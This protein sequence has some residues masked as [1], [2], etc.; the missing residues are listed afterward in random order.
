MQSKQ[1]AP[2]VGLTNPGDS[3][4]RK[5]ESHRE[6]STESLIRR[7]RYSLR[8]AN[9]SSSKKN[10][11]RNRLSTRSCWELCPMRWSGTNSW[12]E[13]AGYMLPYDDQLSNVC[14]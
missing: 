8:C 1:K 2:W 14:A 13:F 5:L 6:L 12:Q 4:C 3:P 10:N 9:R 11:M 7:M